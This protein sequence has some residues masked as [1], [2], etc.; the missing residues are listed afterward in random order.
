[1]KEEVSGAIASP[2]DVLLRGYLTLTPAEFKIIAG[3]P[4]WGMSSQYN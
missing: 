3:A 4:R 1:M 2:K